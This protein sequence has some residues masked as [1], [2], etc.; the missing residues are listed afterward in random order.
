MNDELVDVLDEQGNKTGQVLPKSVVHEKL[1]WHA[2]VH[3]WVYSPSARILMQKRSMKKDILPGQ[4]DISAAGHMA[5]GETP[6]VAAVREIKEE[7]GV[8]IKKTMLQSAGRIKSVNWI[9]SL[10]LQHLEYWYVFFLEL[11]E[12]TK[13]TFEDE[14]VDEVKWL[15]YKEVIRLSQKARFVEHKEYYKLVTTGLKK[16]VLKS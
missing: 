13:F 12:D 3:I 16:R 6:E 5:S 2:A 14:E 11:D 7:L 10:Q 4:W 1:L 15:T 8:T 9:D